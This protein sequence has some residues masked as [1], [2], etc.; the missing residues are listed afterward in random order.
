MFERPTILLNISSVKKQDVCQ[1]KQ[2]K[3]FNFAHS[4]LN[5][6]LTSQIDRQAQ[7]LKE[8]GLGIPRN[9]WYVICSPW[10]GLLSLPYDSEWLEMSTQTL[11]N[12]CN[13]YFNSLLSTSEFRYLGGFSFLHIQPSNCSPCHSYCVNKTQLFHAKPLLNANHLEA[14]KETNVN[15]L[16]L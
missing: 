1:F 15:Y 5:F 8:Y 16:H 4:S 12:W 2:H 11:G 14:G 7:S 13:L 3:H 9:D 6:L 10:W